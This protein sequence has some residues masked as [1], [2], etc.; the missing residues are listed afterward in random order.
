MAGSALYYIPVSGSVRNEEDFERLNW[1]GEDRLKEIG[2]SYTTEKS[3]GDK[4]QGRRFRHIYHELDLLQRIQRLELRPLT[5]QKAG[6][7]P[8]SLPCRCSLLRTGP[9]NRIRKVLPVYALF[10]LDAYLT[11]SWTVPRRTRQI[12]AKAINL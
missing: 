8:L 7:A 10:H 1:R 11:P 5:V 4:N 2:S 6:Q 12:R 9:G 3:P